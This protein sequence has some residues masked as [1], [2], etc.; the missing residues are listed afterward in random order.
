MGSRNDTMASLIIIPF[1]SP[2]PV[3]ARL[4]YPVGP[5]G[6]E[7]GIWFARSLSRRPC[8]PIVPSS[9]ASWRVFFAADV[10]WVS[11]LR[12]TSAAGLSLASFLPGG[13]GCVASFN[14]EAGSS[15]GGGMFMGEIFAGAVVHRLVARLLCRGRLLGVALALNL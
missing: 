5:G 9:T 10:F 4:P 12:L 13:V 11:P 7:R 1:A 8:R 2:A 14:R 3:F 15:I 6:G